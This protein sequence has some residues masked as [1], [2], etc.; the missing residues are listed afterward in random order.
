MKLVTAFILV[1][2]TA[3]FT[4]QQPVSAESQPAD[5]AQQEQ[6][7]TNPSAAGAKGTIYVYRLRLTAG[8]FNKPSIYVDEK[9]IA[10]IR[11]GRF[12]IVNVD[13]GRHVIRSEHKTAVVTLDVNPGQAYYIRVAWEATAHTARAATTLVPP[14]QGWAEIGQTESSDPSDIKDHE[15]A[16]IGT[17]PPK[18]APAPATVQDLSAPG[19]CRTIAVTRSL[20][21]P[22]RFNVL[23][24]VNY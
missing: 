16:V 22:T 12:F 3:A 23:D 13:P 2:A 5:P 10:R 21:P 24:V 11:N 6:N 15:L 1:F 7:A 20:F 19:T 18:P 14:E 17:M 9:E 4:L 8:T